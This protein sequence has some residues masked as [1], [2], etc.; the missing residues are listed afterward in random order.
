MHS[1]V[2]KKTNFYN[3]GENVNLHNILAQINQSIGR[4]MPKS[5]WHALIL[6]LWTKHETRIHNE[7]NDLCQTL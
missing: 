1:Y 3:R 2:K 5:L 6:K 7:T 4:S